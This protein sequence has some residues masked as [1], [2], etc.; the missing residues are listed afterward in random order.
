MRLIYGLRQLNSDNAIMMERAIRRPCHVWRDPDLELLSERSAHLPA[1]QQLFFP[2][3]FFLTLHSIQSCLDNKRHSESVVTQ[4]P[5]INSLPSLPR[6]ELTDFL[7][8]V[9][10]M[11]ET[12]SGGKAE[13]RPRGIFWRGCGEFRRSFFPHSSQP[14]KGLKTWENKLPASVGMEA[15]YSPYLVDW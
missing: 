3:S 14:E 8:A 11:R 7:G 9:D 5:A 10:L 12:K 2:P 13:V 1:F 15:V 4:P 6:T